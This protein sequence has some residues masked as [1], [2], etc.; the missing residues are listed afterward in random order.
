MYLSLGKFDNPETTEE[1]RRRRGLINLIG[2]TMNT[3][4]GVCDDNCVQKTN[5]AIERTEKNGINILH[6]MKSQTTIIKAAMKRIGIS[7]SQAQQFYE[8]IKENEKNFIKNMQILGNA[9]NNIMNMLNTNELQNILSLLTNQYAYETTTL[10]EIITAARTGVIHT[11]LMTPQDIAN[12]LKQVSSKIKARLDLPMGTKPTEIYDLQK[13]TKMSIFYNNNKLV[14]ITKIP[15]IT[16]TELTMYN[17]IPIPIPLNTKTALLIKQSPFIAITKDRK[18]YTQFFEGQLKSCTETS[19]YRICPAFQQMSE[20]V[21][22]PPCEVYLFDNPDEIYKECRSKMYSINRNIYHKLRYSNTWLYSVSNDTLRISCIDIPEPQ[23]VKITETGIITIN[24]Y[25]CTISTDESK[26]VPNEEL[27]TSKFLDFIPKTDKKLLIASL[28]IETTLDLEQYTMGKLSTTN[29]N[30][31]SN[32]LN[33]VEAMVDREQERQE[34]QDKI[35]VN[36]SLFYFVISLGFLCII[37]C[38]ILFV[39]TKFNVTFNPKGAANEPY[40]TRRGH[41]LGGRDTI[42]IQDNRREEYEVIQPPRLQPFTIPPPPP[43]TPADL[44]K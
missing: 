37:L 25:G 38:S 39:I 27:S 16:E 6:I 20:N 5:E 11:N 7:I 41:Y 26:L 43:T 36:S 33:D 10:N 19:M 23:I 18:E 15:L 13:I 2:S 29:L 21:R 4:F 9:T 31:I 28:P 34:I 35:K 44:Q 30:E 1:R 42:G 40:V 17:I 12:T 32:S 3:L 24:D 22:N 14:F 8:T